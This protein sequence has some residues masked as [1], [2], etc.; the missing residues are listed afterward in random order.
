M[1]KR[2]KKKAKRRWK[3]SICDVE[4]DRI[5]LYQIGEDSIYLCLECCK[6]P[7]QRLHDLSPGRSK[8]SSLYGFIRGND[9]NHH[10]S[11]FVENQPPIDFERKFAE[12]NR[13]FVF[14]RKIFKNRK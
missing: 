9:N 13:N 2:V 7:Y 3:C 10:Y 14:N 1:R 4:T 12:K 6:D 8:L 5:Q 11:W